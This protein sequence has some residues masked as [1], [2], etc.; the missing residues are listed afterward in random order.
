MFQYS[1]IVYMICIERGCLSGCCTP[2]TLEIE[3]YRASANIHVVTFSPIYQS[4]VADVLFRVISSELRLD[5]FIAL[6]DLLARWVDIL[7]GLFGC[8][9]IV[10]IWHILRR[11]H[12]QYLVTSLPLRKLL[13]LSASA[14]ADSCRFWRLR[15]N[16]FAWSTCRHRDYLVLEYVKVTCFGTLQSFTFF[17]CIITFN[18]S[19][20]MIWIIIGQICS[21]SMSC[22]YIILLLVNVTRLS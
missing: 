21:T 10:T 20:L 2:F 13:G 7:Q 9:I 12:G 4:R 14:L 18:L 15:S 22:S 3:T 11:C 19:D 8:T 6:S 5:H 16:A 1:T 17:R